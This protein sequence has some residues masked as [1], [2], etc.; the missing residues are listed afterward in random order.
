MPSRQTTKGKNKIEPGIVIALIGLAGTIVAA[1][2]ASPVLIA[3]IQKTPTSPI[4]TPANGAVLPLQVTSTS[5]LFSTTQTTVAGGLQPSVTSIPGSTA[6]SA[7]E[8]PRIRTIP[9]T[10]EVSVAALSP[11]GQIVTAADF[12]GTIKLW[13]TSED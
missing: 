2:F 5:S 8:L 10:G 11:D 3:L 6:V 12:G 13:S 4:T 1:I 9:G 7:N